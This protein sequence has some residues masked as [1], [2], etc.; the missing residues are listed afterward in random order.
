MLGYVLTVA[1]SGC[2]GFGELRRHPGSGFVRSGQ[3]LGE[4]RAIVASLALLAAVGPQ[5]DER[6]EEDLEGRLRLQA[7]NPQAKAPRAATDDHQ[8]PGNGQ[9]GERHASPEMVARRK[10]LQGLA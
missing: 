7:T 8:A 6:Q 5:E 2:S 9:Q 10:L 1:R 3:P 4:G